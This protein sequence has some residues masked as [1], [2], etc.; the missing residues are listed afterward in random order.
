[1]NLQQ[2]Q[3]VMSNLQHGEI[4]LQT[5]Q[6]LDTSLLRGVLQ[7]LD[8]THNEEIQEHLSQE[9]SAP[10]SEA[11][12]PGGYDVEEDR[13]QYGADKKRKNQSTL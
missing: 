6:R 13:R 1:M 9:D 8:N 11:A 4:G 12:D 5:S 3:Q 7:S 2:S 10:H